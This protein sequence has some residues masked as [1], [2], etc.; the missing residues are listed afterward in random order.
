MSRA[1]MLF[2]ALVAVGV[3]CTVTALLERRELMRAVE[4]Y[5]PTP[6]TLDSFGMNDRKV[7]RGGRAVRIS[8]PEATFHYSVNGES[9][10]GHRIAVAPLEIVGEADGAAFESRFGVGT[11][12]T[13]YYD[14]DDPSHAV[15]IQDSPW[16]EFFAWLTVGVGCLLAPFCGW[17]LLAVY[18]GKSAFV[19]PRRKVPRA[20]GRVRVVPDDVPSYDPLARTRRML[21]EHRRAGWE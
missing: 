13:C 5:R 21:D 4:H 2:F 6:C 12:T 20:A 7:I 15:L 19:Q 11:V 14:P 3:G 8:R 16:D 17:G 18:A 9:Y 10:D 1:R